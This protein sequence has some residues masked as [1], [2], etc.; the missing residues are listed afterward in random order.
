[1]TPQQD[2]TWSMLEVPFGAFRSW[3]GISFLTPLAAA[4]APS[5]S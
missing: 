4:A 2:A 3:V 5:W 1:M